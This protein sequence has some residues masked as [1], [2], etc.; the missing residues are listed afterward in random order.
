[1]LT[2]VQQDGGSVAFRI[3]RLLPFVALA[4]GGTLLA[5]ACAPDPGPYGVRVAAYGDPRPNLTP[6][7]AARFREG[8][9]AFDR[10]FTPEEGVGP[11]F[12]ENQCSACHTDPTSGGTGEQVVRKAS[13]FDPNRGCDPMLSLSGG[14]LR[15]RV[16]S[17]S[18]S[19]G[20]LP[21]AVPE[22]AA[23]T[24]RFAVPLLFGLGGADRVPDEVLLGM[25]DPD[26][27]DGDGISGTVGL[28]PQG[29]VGRFGR[30][31]DVGSLLDFTA[32]ALLHEMG[33]TTPVLPHEL[34]RN[35]G[36]LPDGADPTADPELTRDGVE[37]ITDYVRLL[38]VPPRGAGRDPELARQGEAVFEATGCG[39]CHVPTL[40]G[41]DAGE[42]VI[43]YSDLL[44]HDLGDRLAGPCTT[45]A[46][47]GEYRTAPLIGL[48][49]KRSYLHDGRARSLE[50]AV[51]LHG[52]EAAAVGARF[53]S[54]D[55]VARAALLA[56]LG[57]L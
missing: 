13:A 48:G 31:A 45:G 12:N 43:L 20:V 1:M 6:E 29:E 33:I 5:Q 37:R 55:P 2:T 24:G 42:R 21:D 54:L 49:A 47:P 15:Q 32:T 51:S 28:T 19:V 35:G 57:T 16:T 23:H 38:G 30:K 10:V 27:E 44:L 3:R 18:A 53:Q 11:L 25:A 40:S 14:N 22:G 26:D 8:R 39:T 34:G 46:E 17:R 56:F 52:G 41:P 7:E 36:P 4:L 50:A 9:T